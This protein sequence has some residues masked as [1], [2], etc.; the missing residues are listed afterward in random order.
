VAANVLQEVIKGNISAGV[1]FSLMNYE[2]WVNE[3]EKL[4]KKKKK[5]A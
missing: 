5:G 4:N 3:K 1:S 2:M